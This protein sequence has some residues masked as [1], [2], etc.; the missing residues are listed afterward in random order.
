MHIQ[1]VLSEECIKHPGP[2][3]LSDD[4]DNQG[5]YQYKI[6]LSVKEFPL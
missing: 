2:T 5:A 3:I 4:N 6:V 1:I